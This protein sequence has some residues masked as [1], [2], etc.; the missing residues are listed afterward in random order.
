MPF[1][2]G[3]EHANPQPRVCPRRHSDRPAARNGFS[4]DNF[5]VER[6]LEP[7]VL[8]LLGAGLFRRDRRNPFRTSRSF[9]EG[10]INA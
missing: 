1:R 10:E 2:E 4:F 7:S 6:V 5:T 3:V 9:P 8:L